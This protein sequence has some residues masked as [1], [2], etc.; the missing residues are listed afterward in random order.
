M[1]AKHFSA[2]QLS[3]CTIWTLN[4]CSEFTNLPYIKVLLYKKKSFPKKKIVET[5]YPKSRQN[6]N[7]CKYIC[8]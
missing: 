2:I 8:T 5:F 4:Y 7:N 1:M 6:K 3:Y